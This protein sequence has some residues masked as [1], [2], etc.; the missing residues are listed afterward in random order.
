[1]LFWSWCYFGIMIYWVHDSSHS[2]ITHN[3]LVWD[4]MGLLFNFI[5][6]FSETVWFTKHGE[7]SMLVHSNALFLILV[8][9]GHHP[10][11]NISGVDP[12]VSV[13][14]FSITRFLPSQ[15]WKKIYSIQHIYAPFLYGLFTHFGKLQDIT[16]YLNQSVDN[17]PMN[18]FTNTQSLVF[19]GGKVNTLSLRFFLRNEVNCRLT[20]VFVRRSTIPTGVPSRFYIHLAVLPGL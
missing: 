10:Y 11:T 5:L 2:A 19:W 3:P 15:R 1:M 9:L 6:G 18:P 14:P 13:E 16:A 7:F 8:V 20:Q 4:C 17:I 12:D